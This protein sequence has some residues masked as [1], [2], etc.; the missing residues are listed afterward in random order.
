MNKPCMLALIFGLTL[1]GSFHAHAAFMS[2]FFDRQPSIDRCWAQS[3]EFRRFDAA[4]PI[5]IASDQTVACL[6][7]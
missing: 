1:L 3:N 4:A 7:G 6:T 5:R 2:K